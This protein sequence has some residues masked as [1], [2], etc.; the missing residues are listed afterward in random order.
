MDVNREQLVNKRLREERYMRKIW[1]TCGWVLLVTGVALVLMMGL[2]WIGGAEASR[3]IPGIVMGSLFMALGRNFISRGRYFPAYLPSE[4][5][6]AA[7]E[8]HIAAR[9]MIIQALWIGGIIILAVAS[10]VAWALGR[11]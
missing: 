4:N 5:S 8:D 9:R 11:S 3:M 6:E 10:F 7:R 2:G 1:I